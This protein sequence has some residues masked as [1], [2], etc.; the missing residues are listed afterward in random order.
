MISTTAYASVKS[1]NLKSTSDS[2]EVR[3]VQSASAV[4]TKPSPALY[5]RRES[6]E[7]PNLQRTERVQLLLDH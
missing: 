6:L 4:V 5:A 3:A 7:R 1:A 2:Y